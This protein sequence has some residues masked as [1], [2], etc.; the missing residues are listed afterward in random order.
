[1][2]VWSRKFIRWYVLPLVQK[3]NEFNTLA[4]AHLRVIDG[5]LTALDRDYTALAHDVAEL[6]LMLSRMNRSISDI[7]ERLRDPGTPPSEV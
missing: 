1:M 4:T 6:T 3:Q 5:R 7:E 2:K